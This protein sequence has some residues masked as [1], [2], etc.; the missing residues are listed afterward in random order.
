MSCW[1][2]RESLTSSSS[3]RMIS[4]LIA[5]GISANDKCTLRM[6]SALIALGIALTMVSAIPSDLCWVFFLHMNCYNSFS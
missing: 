1:V 2:T 4:A 3:L 6:I 5:L